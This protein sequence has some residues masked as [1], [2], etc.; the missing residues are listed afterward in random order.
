MVLK[1]G[2]VMKLGREMEVKWCMSEI[3]RGGGWVR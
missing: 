1:F 3:V 2:V